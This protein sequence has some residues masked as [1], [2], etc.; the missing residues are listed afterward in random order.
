MLS[1]RLMLCSTN[2][3]C[4]CTCNYATDPT[5]TCRDLAQTINVTLAKTPV[6]A[7]YPLTYVQSFNSKPYEVMPCTT[8]NQTDLS[9]VLLLSIHSRPLAFA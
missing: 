2:G 9:D 6:Y 1:N 7:V 3:K 5:C 4:P 8:Q